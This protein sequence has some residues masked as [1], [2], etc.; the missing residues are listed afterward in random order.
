MSGQAPLVRELK[1]T[2][3][4]LGAAVVGST[5]V[6]EAPFAGTVTEAVFRSAGTVTLN[7]ANYRTFTLFNRGTAG[8]GVV[9]VATLDTSATTLVDNDERAM[10]LSAT[11]AN[12]TVAADDVLEL[13][14]TV[15]GT[16]VAHSGGEVGVSISR[17]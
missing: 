15:T 5:V 8:A 17:T 9:S 16:G 1:A 11:P 4:A 6:G 12:L 13:V 3:V 7:A 14:E 10:V 2:A